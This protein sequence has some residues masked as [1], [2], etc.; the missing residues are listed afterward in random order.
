M[1]RKFKKYEEELKRREEIEGIILIPFK[2][3]RL[4]RWNDNGEEK[5]VL[6]QERT[7][8]EN[9][10]RLKL[11]LSG[12]Y[13]PVV[14][15]HGFNAGNSFNLASKRSHFVIAPYFDLFDKLGHEDGENCVPGNEDAERV[16]CNAAGKQEF[17]RWTA[18][19]SNEFDRLV[20]ILGKDWEEIASRIR[21]KTE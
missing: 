10:E 18:D 11:I 20:K 7:E 6:L 14:Q 21:S 5:Q 9:E 12:Q 4:E 15:N 2:T 13:V 17:S 3:R 1:Y 8:K 16:N 19:E